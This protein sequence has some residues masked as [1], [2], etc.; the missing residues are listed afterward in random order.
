MAL[1]SLIFSISQ[2]SFFA[3]WRQLFERFFNNSGLF[4]SDMIF[5]CNFN[6]GDFIMNNSNIMFWD[7]FFN[8]FQF[9]NFSNFQ[10]SPYYAKLSIFNF[11]VQFSKLRLPNLSALD[12]W[13][14][15]FL[16]GSRCEVSGQD[17]IPF[18]H[19]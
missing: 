8:F 5:F 2:F 9:F 15:R 16:F 11:Q 4:F 17:V 7:E 19:P 14:L 12:Q 6:R 1:I 18:V 3:A 13:H 10:S